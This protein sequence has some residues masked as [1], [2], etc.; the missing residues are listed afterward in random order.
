MWAERGIVLS[1]ISSIRRQV[2]K[3]PQNLVRSRSFRRFN[4]W[5]AVVTEGIFSVVVHFANGGRGCSLHL[6]WSVV[7]VKM[8]KS[9][10]LVEWRVTCGAVSPPP[11]PPPQAI[12]RQS[13]VLPF[14]EVVCVPESKTW[15]LRTFSKVIHRWRVPPFL[16]SEFRVLS[17]IFKSEERC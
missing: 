4:L 7:L 1:R 10:I 16:L 12:F 11:P 17:W 13:F 6:R 14:A 2:R 9:S 8:F 3:A 5:I 15:Q